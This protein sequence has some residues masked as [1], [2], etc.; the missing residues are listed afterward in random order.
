MARHSDRENAGTLRLAYDWR[1]TNLFHLL[2]RRRLT[3]KNSEGPGLLEDLVEE[4]LLHLGGQNEFSHLHVLLHRRRVLRQQPQPRRIA[5]SLEEPL[6]QVQAR[7]NDRGPSE[8]LPLEFVQTGY[9]YV[10]ERQ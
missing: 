2:R 9:V 3:F 10:E 7:S 6:G 5:A 1:L 8:V 4:Q